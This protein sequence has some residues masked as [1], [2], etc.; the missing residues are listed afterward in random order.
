MPKYC[1]KCKDCQ[2]QFE[3]WHSVKIKLKDCPKCEKGVLNR[4][5]FI[6]R[7][8]VN[9]TEKKKAGQRIK[10]FIEDSKQELKEQ[11]NNV[12]RNWGDDKK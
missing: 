10:N 8:T 1:Y 5:P 9:D 7:T 11:I 6:I 2:H 12:D 3:K 4:V